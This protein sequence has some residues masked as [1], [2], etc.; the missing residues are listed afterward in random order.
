MKKLTTMY[1][2]MFAVLSVGCS[3]NK[4][5]VAD[6]IEA[7]ADPTAVTPSPAAGA[8]SVAKEETHNHFR[9]LRFQSLRYRH[10]REK[11]STNEEPK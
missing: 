5:S 7:G 2:I 10:V 8:P 6:A 4:T 1:L 9:K 11:T 3:A